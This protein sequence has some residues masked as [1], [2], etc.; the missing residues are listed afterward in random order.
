M[1]SI[2]VTGGAG[3]IG[4]HT[5]A[6]LLESGQ[7]AVIVDN[8][9][10]ANP[11]VIGILENLY[12]RKI[13]FYE[14]DVCD[15]EAMQRIFASH[16]ISAVIHFAALKAVAESV[17]KPLRYYEVN[18]GGTVSLCAA[19]IEAGVKRLV[20]SSSATVYGTPQR[21]PLREDDPVNSAAVANP[22]GRTKVICEGILQDLCASD[23]EFAV[24]ALRYFNPIG[25]HKSGKIGEDP[26]GVPNNIMP[27]ITRV[28]LG[29]TPGF[30]V[31]GDDYATP[32]CTC[33]RDYVHI[34]D[35]VDGHL[36]ALEY[37]ENH[38]GFEAF[39]LGNGK[40]YSVLEIIHAFEAATGMSVPYEIQERRPGDVA[41]SCADAGKAKRLL[42]WEAKNDIAAMCSDAWRWQQMNPNGYG[43]RC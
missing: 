15:R 42:G 36:A 17:A 18:V 43:A 2:L 20:Y 32:D 38:R 14:A 41:A 11:K 13:P 39:N 35:L 31:F 24:M 33:V 34:L 9:A 5:V 25:A 30:A 8:L 16:S 29:Q 12:Q 7:E 40:G 27:N 10:N 3:Y 26:Q 19:M 23:A 37:M 6:K 1:S 4:S 22:Y 28:A 21:V